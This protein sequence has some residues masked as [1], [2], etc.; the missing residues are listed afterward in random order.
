MKIRDIIEA[1]FPDVRDER[2]KRLLRR[3]H[4]A[5][6]KSLPTTQWNS[7]Q[8]Y[9]AT[10]NPRGGTRYVTRKSWDNDGREGYG[11]YN[12]EYAE[13]FTTDPGEQYLERTFARL[14]QGFSDE[15]PS[16]GPGYIYRGGSQE[17]MD[18]LSQTGQIVS[19]GDY[20][21]GKE[22]VGLTYWSLDPGQAVS[23]SNS[24]AP[25]GHKATFE[26]PAYVW[27][28]RA[29]DASEI[30]KVKGTGENEV[31]VT[32]PIDNDE[33]VQIWRGQVY[34]Y[35]PGDIDLVPHDYES[36]TY[37]LGSGTLPSGRVMWQRIR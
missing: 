29:P 20:N 12:P 11:Y 8:R 4:D 36:K 14:R 30:K 16:L 10:L 9:R 21:M 22:Q 3:G 37:K 28:A 19:H 23:Y 31:G 15:I 2:F 32:R 5:E 17:E 1:E 33:I 34:D 6:I 24:F 35:S 26:H 27:V 25:S 7:Q 13:L 18:F